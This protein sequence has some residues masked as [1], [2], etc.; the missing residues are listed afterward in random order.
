MG[1]KDLL[2]QAP[3]DMRAQDSRYGHFFP[4]VV[5][6]SYAGHQMRLYMQHGMLMHFCQL[7][8]VEKSYAAR[9]ILNSDN[10]QSGHLI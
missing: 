1:L 6:G 10:H 9:I 7:T 4:D 5:S 3:F 8:T 2:M